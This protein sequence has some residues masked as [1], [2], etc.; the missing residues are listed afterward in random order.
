MPNILRS[1]VFLQTPELIGFHCLHMIQMLMHFS[2]S[3]SCLSPSQCSQPDFHF[4][5]L[6]IYKC[7]PKNQRK[8]REENLNLSFLK[9]ALEGFGEAIA[10]EI[11]EDR[12]EKERLAFIRV[13]NLRNYLPEKL[14]NCLRME[15]ILGWRGEL[16]MAGRGRLTRVVERQRQSDWD[17]RTATA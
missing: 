7:L 10:V 5:I 12:V 9:K 14:I 11:L 1:L 3:F 2:S 4:N 16:G 15:E 8:S 13:A 17:G 6:H